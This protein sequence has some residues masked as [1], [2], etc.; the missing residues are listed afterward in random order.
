MIWARALLAREAGCDM[1]SAQAAP[2][3][4]SAR[5]LMSLGLEQ[6]VTRDVYR[7]PPP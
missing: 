7:F 3:T 6:L 1:V 4:V 2:G 5:N